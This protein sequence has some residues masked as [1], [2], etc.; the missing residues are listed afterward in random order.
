[1]ASSDHRPTVGEYGDYST[2]AIC[3]DRSPIVI[4]RSVRARIGGNPHPA[5]RSEHD[6]KVCRLLDASAKNA[7]FVIALLHVI[8]V[9][10][11]V[12]DRGV[13]TGAL[14]GLPRH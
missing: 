9:A 6:W 8:D 14:L 13:R 5:A 3:T 7:I 4:T 10:G 11:A 2:R 12:T 1:M